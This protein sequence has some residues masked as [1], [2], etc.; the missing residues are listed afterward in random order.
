MAGLS[1]ILKGIT[2]GAARSI[3]EAMP[4]SQ[5]DEGLSAVLRGKPREVVED[6]SES[7]SEI[8]ADPKKL[9]QYKETW[10]EIP[11]N[12]IPKSQR[13]SQNP[14][15]QKAM[16]KFYK[17]DMNPN[18]LDH[19]INSELPIKPITS[20]NFPYIAEFE[21][22]AGAL[23]TNQVREGLIGFNKAIDPENLGNVR[24]ATRLDIPAYNVH[25]KW[26]VTVHEGGRKGKALGYGKTAVLK[27][28][29]FI[30]DPKM[31]LDIAREKIYTVGKRAGK[32][33]GKSTFARMDG[34]WQNADPEEVAQRAKQLLNDPESGWI[35]VGMNP[36][37][38]SYFY[39]KATMQPLMSAEEVI[40]VGPLVLARGVKK[41]TPF[42]LDKYFTITTTK[43]TQE[44]F[45]KGGIVARNPYPEARAII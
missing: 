18:E 6:T 12:T 17:G 3:P 5:V 35:Q 21:E 9:E 22:M 25:D 23:K 31:A 30:T 14:T 41:P 8:I 38:H 26:I 24:V 11:G 39:D 13:Q 10:K 20:D 28:V 34:L 45:K 33:Q 7:L 43:G 42:E 1:A 44:R 16:Q 29:T 2:K 19:I 37:R 36:Y 32:K 27:D 15:L 4:L 40:Q